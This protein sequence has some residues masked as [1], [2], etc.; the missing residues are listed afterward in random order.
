MSESITEA[1][2]QAAWRATGCPVSKESPGPTNREFFRQIYLAM[3]DAAIEDA[4]EA[5]TKHG[6]SR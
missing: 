4:D 5:L 6:D 1:M 2:F 3:R